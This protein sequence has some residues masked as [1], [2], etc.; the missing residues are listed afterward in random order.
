LLDS[1]WPLDDADDMV[2]VEQR[3]EQQMD[4]REQQRKAVEAHE[5]A[6]VDDILARLHSSGIEQLSAEDRAILQRASERYR[7]KRR[8]S[9]D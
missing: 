5:D 6:R 9:I 8:T 3:T 2:L 1:G 4:R 7:T